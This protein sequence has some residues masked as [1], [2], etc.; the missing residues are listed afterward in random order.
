[1]DSKRRYVSPRNLFPKNNVAQNRSGTLAISDLHAV[2][3]QE[4]VNIA[5]LSK[6]ET[7]STA[8]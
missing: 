7:I 6:K 2:I 5:F 3:I 8:F 4:A 1:M